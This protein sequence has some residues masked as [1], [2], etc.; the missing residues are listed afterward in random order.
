MD[1]QPVDN[2]AAAAPQHG[3]R[4]GLHLSMELLQLLL[5]LPE[6]RLQGGL[7]M[8]AV[9][10]PYLAQLCVVL[11]LEEVCVKRP[12]ALGQRLRACSD[13]RLV[14]VCD[15]ARQMFYL[16]CAAASFPSS[17]ER[18]VEE[19]RPESGRKHRGP[20]P[21]SWKNTNEAHDH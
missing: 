20:G 18:T 13:Q 10:S 12:R 2:P 14:R 16:L 11:L 3:H 21:A 7:P 8:G 15:A 19:T 1:S 17:R 5:L 6:Q 9:T 4:Q